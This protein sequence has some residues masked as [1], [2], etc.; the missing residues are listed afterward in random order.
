MNNRKI[1]KMTYHI[2]GI[3]GIMAIQTGYFLG[4]PIM[5]IDKVQVK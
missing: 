3:K 2:I 4:Y 1:L 5:R